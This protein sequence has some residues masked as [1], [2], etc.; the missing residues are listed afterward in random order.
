MAFYLSHTSDTNW[1]SNIH[2]PTR[3]LTNGLLAIGNAGIDKGTSV[4][5]I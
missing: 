1:L 4:S 5:F 3:P 2:F